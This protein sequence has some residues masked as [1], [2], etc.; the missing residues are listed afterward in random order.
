MSTT[1]RVGLVGTGGI[2]NAHGNACQQAPSA[3]LAAICD[4]SENALAN[5]GER[6]DVAPEN[7]Y[8]SLAEMLDAE[9]LDIAVICT[10]G[11]F[12]AEVGISLLNPSKS[13][14]SLCEKPFTSTSGGGGSVRRCGARERCFSGGGV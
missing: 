11:A 10:W 6:F 4:V 12:H 8:L 9:N 13:K 2:A 3:E 7:Q 1:Y 5:F 14:R